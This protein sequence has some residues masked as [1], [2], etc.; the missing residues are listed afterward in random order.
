[1]LPLGIMDWAQQLDGPLG[2]MRQ[3]RPAQRDPGVGQ[4]LV[5][6][7]RNRSNRTVLHTCLS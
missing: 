3:C 6:T 2:V 5:L 1:M 7:V 4:T